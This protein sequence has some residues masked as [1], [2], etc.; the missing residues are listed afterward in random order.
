MPIIV[1]KREKETPGGLVRRF[2]KIVKQSGFVLK[3]RKKRFY[4][5]PLTKKKKRDAALGRAKTAK[6]M[7]R[8][9]KLGKKKETKR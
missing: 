5:K 3:T 4:K 6:E 8:L 2:T 1:R 7:E 9:E